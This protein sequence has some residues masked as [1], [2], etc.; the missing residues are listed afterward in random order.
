V[1]GVEQ[2]RGRA[3]RR[4]TPP[5]DGRLAAGTDD[6]DRQAAAAQQLGGGL[7]GA[8][9]VGMVE[10]VERHAGDAD[11][12]LQIGPYP[13]QFARDRGAQLGLGHAG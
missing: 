3:L 2:H 13:G 8:L 10:A 12:A 4:G 7:G 6:V 5:D 11:Q 1:V 9:H